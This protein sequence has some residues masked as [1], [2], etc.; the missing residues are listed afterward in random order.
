MLKTKDVVIEADGRDRG[1]VFL[2]TEM[3]SA[4]AERW[5]AKVFNG[6]ARSN[7]EIPDT[8]VGAGIVGVWVMGVKML[9]AMDFAICEDLMDEMMRCVQFIPDKTHPEI[10]RP[11]IGALAIESDIEEVE[12]RI[13]LRE[14]VFALHVGFTPAEAI[15]KLTS[16]LNPQDSP[17]TETS[18]AS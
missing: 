1:K 16:A 12:T 8:V 15:S 13:K 7:V 3:P 6:L 11:I 9:F 5:A 18:P 14:E 4:R 17:N 10:M 2:L